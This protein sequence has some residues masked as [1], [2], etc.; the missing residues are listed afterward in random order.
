MGG[1]KL[2]IVNVNTEMV[3]V[4]WCLDFCFMVSLIVY[5]KLKRVVMEIVPSI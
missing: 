4:V 1:K 2:K 5:L 3:G